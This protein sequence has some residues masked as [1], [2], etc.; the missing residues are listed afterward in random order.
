MK[1]M[2]LRSSSVLRLLTCIKQNEDK[3][4]GKNL[5]SA[6]SKQ[7]KGQTTFLPQPLSCKRHML[8]P[9]AALGMGSVYPKLDT[10]PPNRA[11]RNL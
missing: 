5:P 6:S 10:C 2:V 1:K 4:L 3:V 7:G 9:S 11:S 8:S